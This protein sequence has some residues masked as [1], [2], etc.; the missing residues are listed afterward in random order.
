M[1]M[2]TLQYCNVS[3]AITNVTVQLDINYPSQLADLNNLQLLV[4][5]GITTGGQATSVIMLWLIKISDWQVDFSFLNIKWLLVCDHPNPTTALMLN[6]SD[7]TLYYNILLSYAIL[8]AIT[9]TSIQVDPDS[10][11]QLA[12][13]DNLELVIEGITT[14]GQATSV[15]WR[16]N[17][18]IV[19]RNTRLAGGR[20]FYDGGGETIVGT[21]SCESHMYRVALLVIGYLPG[22]YT[23]TVSNANT[24]TP[25]TSPVLIIQG[26]KKQYSVLL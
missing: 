9:N 22:S 16:R 7:I 12:D 19:D 17:N 10:S 18:V 1:Y 20:A 13:R 6:E 21:G 23:Y 26:N 8:G 11:S 3:G 24:S 15:T 5:E 25:V 2:N 14:G 4:I